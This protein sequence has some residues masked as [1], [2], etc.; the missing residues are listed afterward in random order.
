MSSNKPPRP[1]KIDGPHTEEVLNVLGKEISPDGMAKATAKAK[2]ILELPID[3]TPGAPP[4][5]SD[6]LLYG[7]I[8]SGKTSILT[9][10][11]AMAVDNGFDCVVV[12]TTDNDPLYEQ[13]KDRVRAALG[14][15]TVLGKKDWKDKARFA[16][17]IKAKPFAIVCSKNG[18]MLTSLVE[19]FKGGQSKVTVVTYSG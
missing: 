3:P 17:Q 5:S 16:K 18:S 13:T 14:G 4:H 2:R 8:Q 15:L 19:A 9:L 1:I 7:L 6:G 11:S 12:L 10:T